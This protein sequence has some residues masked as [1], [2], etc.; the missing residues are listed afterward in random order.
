MVKEL[1]NLGVGERLVEEKGF[2]ENISLSEQKENYLKQLMRE[3][4]EGI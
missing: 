4:M 2:S 3:M 1:E